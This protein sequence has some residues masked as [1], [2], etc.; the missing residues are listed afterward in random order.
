MWGSLGCRGSWGRR[1]GCSRECRASQ[2]QVHIVGVCEVRESELRGVGGPGSEESSRHMSRGSGGPRGWGR[3]ARAR[4]RRRQRGRARRYLTASAAAVA[5]GPDWAARAPSA[6]LRGPPL[7]TLFALR[8]W[9]RRP[10]GSPLPL[11]RRRRRRPPHVGRGPSPPRDLYVCK[12]AVPCDVAA[13]ELQTVHQG[14]CVS[15]S[16]LQG[17]RETRLT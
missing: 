6:A 16:T 10:P 2:E 5:P 8:L 15:G 7:R 13:L 14:T 3:R 1:G 11:P 12:K 17:S 9:L 4:V